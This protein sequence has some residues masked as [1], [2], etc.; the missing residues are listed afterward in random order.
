LRP[1]CERTKL[2][3]IDMGECV[4]MDATAG[5][6][7]TKI[8]R[9][10]RANSITLIYAGVAE[11][12][13]DEYHQRATR[14]RACAIRALRALWLVLLWAGALVTGALRLVLLNANL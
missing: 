10:M 9:L 6:I 2:L 4:A 11:S 5:S 3:I 1:R 13:E 7:F 12:V 14:T 8:Q